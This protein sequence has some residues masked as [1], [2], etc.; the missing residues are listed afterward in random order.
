[1][2][3]PFIVADQ[4]PAEKVSDLI[5]ITGASILYGACR[6][7]LANLTARGPHGMVSLPSVSFMSPSGKNEPTKAATSRAKTVPAGKGGKRE[8]AQR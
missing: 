1:M 5:K 7:M 4:Y 6:E 8:K 3:G 2:A